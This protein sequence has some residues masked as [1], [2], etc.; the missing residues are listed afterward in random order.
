MHNSICSNNF[1]SIIPKEVR[2]SNGINA[3]WFQKGNNFESDS[4]C[5]VTFS[6][7][8]IQ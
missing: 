8:Q 4:S 1:E 5:K 7:A 2:I 3:K 6:K